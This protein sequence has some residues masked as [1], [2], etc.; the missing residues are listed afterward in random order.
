MTAGFDD[1]DPL[2][3][4]ARQPVRD[5][6]RRRADA[7][8]K[9]RIGA[10][11]WDAAERLEVVQ[12]FVGMRGEIGFDGAHLPPSTL[13]TWP[14]IQPAKSDAKN[15]T[16][17]AMSSGEPSRFRAMFCEEPL[18]AVLAHRLPLPL[19]GR[20][21][22]DEARRDVVDGDVPGPE[23]MGELARQPDLPGLGAGIGLDAGEADAEAGAAGDVDHPAVAPAA[24]CRARPPA[25]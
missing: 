2:E 16:I 19:G 12:R 23:L 14:L 5:E 15:I 8:A 22:A 7:V 25:S 6:L 4:G 21:G 11:A 24:S 18:L 20:V 10:D 1:L 3:A 13:I 9:R 17:A